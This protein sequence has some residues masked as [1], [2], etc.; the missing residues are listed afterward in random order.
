LLNHGADPNVLTHTGWS[1]LMASA[2]RGDLL[3][4][5]LLLHHG[6]R[7]QDGAAEPRGRSALTV[8]NACEM[9]A[10]AAAI[11]GGTELHEAYVTLRRV[12]DEQEEGRDARTLLPALEAAAAAGLSGSLPATGVTRLET[13]IARGDIFV[14]APT[15]LALRERLRQADLAS[16]C[17]NSNRTAHPRLS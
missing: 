3:M 8:A 12:L 2:Q 17:D 10:C 15:V 13:L 9:H 1:P 16:G 14:D 6:A 5:R 11:A 7:P 4:V